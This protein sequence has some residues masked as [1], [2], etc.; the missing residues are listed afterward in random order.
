MNVCYL[1]C[2]VYANNLRMHTMHVGYKI[3]RSIS[4]RFS[5]PAALEYTVIHWWRGPNGDGF[6]R[7]EIHVH[8]LSILLSY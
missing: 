1:A 8:V 6:V 2:L 4:A 5:L 3:A 7:S